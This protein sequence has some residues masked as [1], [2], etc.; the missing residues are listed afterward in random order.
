MEELHQGESRHCCHCGGLA[1]SR[2][3]APIDPDDWSD[4]DEVD[5]V[6]VDEQAN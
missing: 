4:D 1:M 5:I 2:D 3:P 6:P